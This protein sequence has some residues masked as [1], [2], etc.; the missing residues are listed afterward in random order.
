MKTSDDIGRREE[1]GKR[2]EVYL[3]SA[4]YCDTLKAL[5]RVTFPLL[6]LY[7]LAARVVD[8]ADVFITDEPQMTLELNALVGERMKVAAD[9]SRLLLKAPLHLTNK[10]HTPI[11]HPE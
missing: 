5:R 3:Y 6:A 7:N 1:K 11:R 4:I 2:K 9:T 8:E 10:R